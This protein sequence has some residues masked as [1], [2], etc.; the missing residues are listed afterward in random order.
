MVFLLVKLKMMG[1]QES[2]R[3]EDF[4]DVYDLET[5]FDSYRI[6]LDDGED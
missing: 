5:A 4:D 6:P 3:I 1:K 2:D